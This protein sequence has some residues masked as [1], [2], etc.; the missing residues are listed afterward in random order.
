[1]AQ[2]LTLARQSADQITDAK[3]A[4]WVRQNLDTIGC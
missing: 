1:M 3:D 4:A 2:H